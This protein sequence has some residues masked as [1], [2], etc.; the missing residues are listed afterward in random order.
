MKAILFASIMFAVAA[1]AL[2]GDRPSNR[3]EGFDL[4]TGSG[5]YVDQNWQSGNNGER[6]PNPQI[7]KGFQGWDKSDNT[8]VPDY[9]QGD[10][11]DLSC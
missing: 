9:R 5:R 11:P 1:P 8:A 2:A 4:R 3:D 6:I 7:Y 10:C